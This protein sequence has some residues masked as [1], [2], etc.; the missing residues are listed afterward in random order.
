MPVIS[1][2]QALH[3]VLVYDSKQ[4]HR[5]SVSSPAQDEIVGPDM[6]RSLGSEP[7]SLVIVFYRP[8]VLTQFLDRRD[9]LSVEGIE[10]YA[11]WA[12]HGVCQD[13]AR[14]P[15]HAKSA[16]VITVMDYDQRR[17][18]PVSEHHVQQRRV[19]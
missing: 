1:N 7:E 16:D 9:P 19:W 15:T 12:Q 2:R 17:Q 5:S 6:V 3:G 10:L 18:S 8:F 13:K 4:P 14:H 11:S